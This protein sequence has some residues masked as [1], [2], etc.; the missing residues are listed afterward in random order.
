ML[1]SVRTDR[2]HTE[3]GRTLTAREA[4]VARLVARGRTNEE[5]AAELQLSTKT[6]EW[7]L[8]K[9]YRALG[10]R[11]RTELAIEAASGRTLLA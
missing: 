4:A 7:N 10:V 1:C 3:V 5:V 11:S 2:L 8:T 9:V 6:V